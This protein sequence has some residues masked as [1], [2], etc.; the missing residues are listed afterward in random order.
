MKITTIAILLIAA[1]A[2]A[3][4][5]FAQS[6]QAPSTVTQLSS[7]QTKLASV[8]EAPIYFRALHVSVS[9][10]QT[11]TLSVANGIL[12]PALLLFLLFNQ[13]LVIYFPAHCVLQ[14][15]I[16]VHQMCSSPQWGQR[17][18]VMESCCNAPKSSRSTWIP[19]ENGR[20]VTGHFTTTTPMATVRKDPPQRDS[21]PLWPLRRQRF[22]PGERSL[23]PRQDTDGMR[24]EIAAPDAAGIK[25]T[26]S[27]D[28][29]VYGRDGALAWTNTRRY[30]AHTSLIR[31]YR[32][33]V[34]GH[35][36]AYL[37]L[38]A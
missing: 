31:N 15:V 24:L 5:A 37:H 1:G 8:V 30:A 13:K 28:C 4:S 34:R 14:S 29:R 19:V 21:V 33:V 12:Y 16:G 11:S 7:L 35:T 32:H 10:G 36:Q 6:T 27:G 22:E 9:P 18:V 3:A 20:P 25:G 26:G 2:L 23:R 38:C 17:E